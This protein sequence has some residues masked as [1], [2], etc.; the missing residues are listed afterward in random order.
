MPVDHL[1]LPE[2]DALP[3]IV[4]MRLPSGLVHFVVVWRVHGPF[5]QVMD[6]ARGRRWV[7]RETF[8]RDVYVHRLA[9]SAEAF[10]EWAG[11]DGFTRPLARRLRELG[12]P[13][14]EALIARALEDPGWPAIA[15]L[16]GA[17][18]TVAALVA[19]GAVAGG[20]ARVGSEPAGR[21]ADVGA[22][23][24]VRRPFRQS[25]PRRRRPRRPRT[26]RRRSR[27]AAPSCCARRARRRSTAGQKAALPVELRAAVE[28][29]APAPRGRALAPA[30]AATG[31]GA[32][33]RSAAASCSR[34]WARS[35]RR[36]CSGRSSMS[37]RGGRGR[38]VASR[39]GRGP[40][41]RPRSARSGAARRRDRRA[42]GGAARARAPAGGRAAAGGRAPRGAAAGLYLRKIPRL[43]DRYF[44]SRPVSDM[45]ERAHLLHRLRALPS[46]GRRDRPRRDRDR[47]RS[48][49]GWPG[50][51]R[52]ARRWR[53]RSACRALLIPFLAEP[54]VAERDLRM[55]NHAGALGRFYLDGL[56]GLVAV[57]THGAEPALAREHRDRLREWVAAARRALGAALTAEAAQTLLGLGAGGSLAG[58]VLRR[59]AA[60]ARHPGVWSWDIWTIRGRRCCVVYWALSLPALGQEL[61]ALVQQIPGAAEPHLASPRAARR[62]RG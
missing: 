52:A 27:S 61:A 26:A 17:T 19:S 57:R 28:E 31:E 22:A 36:C 33:R 37:R 32:G 23:R 43:P 3:A 50:S 16:D 6:P 12:A 38:L 21:S 49:A 2:A 40:R 47:G 56:L 8:L 59:A 55:R 35:S 29:R 39:R 34:R 30:G 11:S 13:D 44:Q 41:P 62:A 14:G 60:A 58:R 25:S 9:I 5:V 24:V 7:R 20:S 46:A 51:I 10:R 18:R 42:A 53:W 48:P 4:V 15:A 1:L 45:A 54:A